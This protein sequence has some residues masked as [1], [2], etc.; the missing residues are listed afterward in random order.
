M[1]IINQ[2][3]S[4]NFDPVKRKSIDVKF[5][6]FHY[7]GMRS[8]EKAIKK[9]RANNSKVSCH[10][11]ITKNGKILNM[12]PDNYTS[13]HAGYSCWRKKNQLNKNS[14][15]IEIQNPGHSFGYKNFSKKQI[16]SIV[17]LSKI[18]IKK[19]RIKNVNF[20]GHS[21]VAPNRKKDPGEKF[22]WHYLSNHKIGIWH[23][24]RK[25]YLKKIRNKSV[26]IKDKK[27]FFNSLKKIG[28]CFTH[29]NSKDFK[30]V[31]K[32]FQRRFRT[33]EISGKIDKECV[34]IAKNLVKCGLN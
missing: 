27:A 8:E 14:I 26:S 30:G 20:L 18:L 32:A 5:V 3:Y 10:Y 29:V 34:E 22:P 25:D 6:I 12:V 9:L 2:L 19:F 11:F 13:W 33:C 7:T 15:G 1:R 21:D 28:Y 31:I 4:K 23:N 17:Y 24:L 16:R